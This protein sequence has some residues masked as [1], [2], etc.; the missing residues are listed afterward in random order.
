MKAA[1]AVVLLFFARFAVAAWYY[2]SHDADI[3]WQAWLGDLI[4]RTRHLP[5]HL[6][7]Q[8]FTAPGA[9][10]APQEW[11]FSIAVAW[12]LAHG[13]FWIVALASACAAAAAMVIT[14]YRAVRRGA[15]PMPVA[16]AT[17]CVGFSVMQ[18]YG[19]RAQVFGWPLL[20]LLLLALDTEGNAI[21]WAI[22]LTALWANLHASALIAPA[23]VLVWGIGTLIEE[24]G[25]TPRVERAAVTAAGCTL[26]VFAT[27]LLWH[28]PAAA[29]ALTFSPI[30]H[31]IV[32]WRPPTIGVTEFT[33]G[34]LP[35]L[36]TCCY[37]GIAAPR[38]RWR[39]GMV[40]AFTAALA[41][42]A[43]RHIPL[44]AIAIAPMAA[45]RASVF[46]TWG[47]RANALLRDRFVVALLFCAASLSGAAVAGDLRRIPAIGGNGLLPTAAIAKAAAIPGVHRLYCEDF[48]WCSLAL[49]Q[50]R[51]RTFLDGRC[52]PFPPRV[53][54]A[55]GA[56]AHTAPGWQQTLRRYRVDLVLARAEAPLGRA[57]AADRAWHLRYRD[58]RYALF[59]RS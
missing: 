46:F 2:P 45:Q 13:A 9:A 43:I 40:F 4:M 12:T 44:A 3:A 54:N 22:P 10:W 5:L 35:L 29:V 21:F 31:A 53:W 47:H 48:S 26:A 59:E 51:L 1:V 42:T 16:L 30:H 6:G 15:M 32:E 57:L 38:E 39:D 19:A 8:A 37:F 49:R 24:R 33:A 23:I 17:I 36:A 25:W 55:Y 20:A 27:P 52:D 14:A 58:A 50:P 56:I 7:S 18:S 41:F 34:F 11:A 28:M